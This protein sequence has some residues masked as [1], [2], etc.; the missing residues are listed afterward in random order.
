MNRNLNKTRT[1]SMNM[2]KLTTIEC[3]S[4]MMKTGV[5]QPPIRAY[6]DDRTVTTTSVRGSRWILFFNSGYNDTVLVGVPRKEPKKYLQHP[7]ERHQCCPSRG[8]RPGVV[9]GQVGQVQPTGPFQI[10]DIS[11]RS[12]P[13]DTVAV[14]SL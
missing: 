5:G 2:K 1:N 7:T 14:I 4:P 3:Q 11:A 12:T 9:A 8:R 13:Q 10:V 6:M